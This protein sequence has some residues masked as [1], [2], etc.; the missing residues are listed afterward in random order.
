MELES[1]REYWSNN[2]DYSVSFGIKMFL[3]SFVEFI[4]ETVSDRSSR[5]EDL[6][7]RS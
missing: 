6:W 2:L 4:Q 1:P 5:G 7:E 3:H